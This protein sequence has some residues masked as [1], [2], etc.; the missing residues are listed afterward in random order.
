MRGIM[1]RLWEKTSQKGDKYWTVIISGEPYSVW[2]EALLQ[3]L[4]P[5]DTVEFSFT[6]SGQYRKITELRKVLNYNQNLSPWLVQQ[7]EKGKR[8]ARMSCLRTAAQVLDSKRLEPRKKADL[9][10]QIARL[11]EN[12]VLGEHSDPSVSSEV[13]P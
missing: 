7:T 3:N 6:Q 13:A 4:R 10:I 2:T 8:I 12:Y 9:I 11:L 5:G 1:E